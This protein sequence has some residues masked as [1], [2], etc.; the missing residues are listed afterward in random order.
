MPPPLLLIFFKFFNNPFYLGLRA[1]PLKLF[2]INNKSR[3]F[4]AGTKKLQSLFSL[5]V[6]SVYI[7]LIVGVYI[8]WQS[9][10]GGE[11]QSP[12]PPPPPSSQKF[13]NNYGV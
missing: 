1:E 4:I 2:S 9:G 7:L 12:P 11:T 3:R 5:S 6:Y 10:G 8:I 13:C